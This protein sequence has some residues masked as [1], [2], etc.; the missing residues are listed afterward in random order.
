MA[1]VIKKRVNLDFLGDEY[2]EAYLTFKAIPLKDYEAI[3][4][5]MPKDT[6]DNKKALQLIVKYLKQYFIGGK[7]PNDKGELEDVS[8]E[9]VDELDAA[10]ALA[11]FETLTGQRIDPK[12]EAPSTS[13]STTEPP[14]A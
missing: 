1:I 7:F 14:S 5:E 4:D 11:C 8:V 9:D 12:V 13:T 3:I 6:Q 10:T 2:K